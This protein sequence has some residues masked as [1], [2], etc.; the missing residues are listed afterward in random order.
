MTNLTDG[1]VLLSAKE[2]EERYGFKE[3]TLAQWRWLG[4]GPS[5]SRYGRM[6]KYSVDDIETF[7]ENRKVKR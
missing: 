1:R 7:I 2:V 6:I 4:T 3:S 5:F